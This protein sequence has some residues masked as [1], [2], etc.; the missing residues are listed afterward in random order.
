M[1]YKG[2]RIRDGKIQIKRPA[3]GN[4][5]NK[6]EYHVK[7]SKAK[8]I[9][10]RAVLFTGGFIAGSLIMAVCILGIRAITAA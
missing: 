1:N 9:L 3:R 7:I 8:R 4:Q 5:P 2:V 6:V 10:Q